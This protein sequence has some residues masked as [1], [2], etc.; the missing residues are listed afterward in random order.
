MNELVI[1]ASGI[2]ML[3]LMTT[4]HPC[5]LTTNLAAVSLITGRSI[6]KKRQRIAILGFILG[7]ACSF[8]G[9]ALILSLSLI[10]IPKLSMLL[11]QIISA[12]LGP[13]LVL[14]GMVLS[15]LINLNRYFSGVNL[16]KKYWL[17]NGS[18]I[19]SLLL[20]A[21]LA[22]SFCPATASIFF[23]I[24]IPVSL[25]SEQII[26]FPFL[27]GLGAILPII[28]ISVVI[29]YGMERIF[30]GNWANRLPK[31]AGWILI[32]LGIY[33]TLEQLYL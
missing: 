3:G 32:F 28:T 7:Y 8:V 9:I 11:Q 6:E 1:T 33:I 18:A 22:L 16:N 14:V 2:F 15:G 25:K 26:L 31:V 4:L 13:L 27:Y 5:P 12:F 30:H 24:M 21:L 17:T 10:A 29:S 23:G 19:S 20:G